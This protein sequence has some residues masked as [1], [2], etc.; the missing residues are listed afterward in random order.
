MT[1][2]P[3]QAMLPADNRRP[4]F[5]PFAV[6]LY[7]GNL[8]LR[9]LVDLAFAGVVVLTFTGG[10]AE[11]WRPVDA[12]IKSM[13]SKLDQPIS[14]VR[15][16][17]QS[18]TTMLS[19]PGQEVVDG[20]KPPAIAPAIIERMP[21]GTAAALKEARTK[22]MAGQAR[23]AFEFLQTADETDPAIAYAKAVAILNYPGKDQAIAAQRL[24][25]QATQKAFAPAFT[26]NGQVLY[27]LLVLD[28]RGELP[29]SDR[30]TLDGAG[31]VVNV[32]AAQLASEAVLWWQRGAAFHDPEALRL[33][34]M[35]EARGF[36]G[37][38]NL[39]AAIAY[40]HDAANRGDALARLELAKLYYEGAG[41]Q[42]DSEKAIMLYRQAADQGLSRA[43][44][45][46]GA[47][48]TAKG[49]TGDLDAAKD[50]IR[51]LDT[52]AR[53]STSAEE[54]G[55]SQWVL[56]LL[57]SKGAPP[58]LRDPARALEHFRMALRL[59]NRMARA[60]LCRA[61]ETGVGTERDLVRA[62]SCFMAMVSKSSADI[63]A[64]I[65]R[66]TRN[67]NESELA[68]AKALQPSEDPSPEFL[69]E[70]MPRTGTPALRLK[71]P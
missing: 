10:F 34:G 38:A 14:V 27:R 53:T 66:V 9:G 3:M 29:Y 40:W 37:K 5:F 57:L 48:L 46:L 13:T 1:T 63:S 36:N 28:E 69:A 23:E 67:L 18:Y 4:A 58:A 70:Y 24:L 20:M 6:G 32:T 8:L 55:I 2:P 47:A 26:L 35:A 19:G 39:P 65:A 49:I 43:A 25:R 17:S 45:G 60:P 7:R 68:R 50:A 54:R 62:A 21:A 61:Y 12:L 30:V 31:R 15:T 56:G 52:V 41:V 22:L 33:L 51:T 64:D 11:A 16:G 42:A 71:R 44:L 59:G